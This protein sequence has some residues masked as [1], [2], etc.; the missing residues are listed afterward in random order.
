[1]TATTQKKF[2]WSST[3]IVITLAFVLAII[4]PFI[5]ILSFTYAYSRPALINDSE[6]RLQNDAL[7]RVQLID[8]YLN[9]RVLDIKTLA[10]VPSVQSFVIETPQ[11]TAAYKNDATHAGYSLIAGVFRDKNYQ[12][13][14]LF[15]IKE[16]VLLSYPVAPVK[17]GN[18]F[19]P[20]DAQGIMQGQTVLSPVYYNPQSNLATIDLYSPITAPTAQLNKPGPIIGYIRA[21]LSLNYIWNNIVQPDQ[22][23]N[24]SGSTAFMLDE[25]G[26]RIADASKQNLFTTVKP[27]DSTVANTIEQEQRYGTSN[28]PKVQANSAIANVLN[29]TPSSATLQT[30]P[31]GKNETYQVVALTTKNPF[32]HWYYFVLSPVSTVTHV[33]NQQLLATLGIAL[34]EAFVVGIIALFAQRSLVRPI[35]GAVESLRSNS[36]MLS[37]LAQRQ[38]Q[39]AEEQMFIIDSSQGKLQS[40]QYYTDATKTALQRLNA[41]ASQL[42]ENWN[43]HDVQNMKNI[44][45][46]LHALINYLEGAS[47]YQDNSNRKLAD[48][49]N[50]TTLTNE[51]L[52]SGSI[53][54]TEAAEQARIIVMQ[55]L[56]VIGKTN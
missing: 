1:M 2:R 13:W 22:G 35:L 40:V 28:L 55:L 30:Q 5:A 33:A 44:M 52:H 23:S 15:D 49:L 26:V 41:I 7:T 21:T 34:L 3:S 50:S 27:L 9:E 4:I 46:Q 18:T 6:Q 42:T 25:N 17:R 32:E 37:S 31:T 14:T 8:T 36:T 53:S 38:Q 10:Q 51:I 45:Q 19:I 11:P 20:A 12:T 43:R 48:V 54:A 47:A 29:T 16:N 39:A 56:S 24:G